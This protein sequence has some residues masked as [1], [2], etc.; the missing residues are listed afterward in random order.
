MAKASTAAAQ[1]FPT[2]VAT[3]QAAPPLTVVDD[4][5]D[6]FIGDSGQGREKVGVKDMA[7]PFWVI[8][9]KTSPEVDKA[10]G[11]YVPG[12]EQGMIFNTVTKECLSGDDGIEVLPCFY[13]KIVIEWTPRESGG[14]LVAVHASDTPLLATAGRNEKNQFVKAG[15]QNLLVETAQHYVVL[16]RPDGTTESGLVA[17]ASTQ[18]KASRQWN[19][20]MAAVQLVGRN[21][22]PFNPPT[23]S[24][25]YRLTTAA[26]S[27]N[28]GSWFGWKVEALDFVKS[29]TMYETAKALYE[30]VKLGTVVARPTRQE[31]GDGPEAAGKSGPSPY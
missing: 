5:T 17:M 18:L 31:D 9:Q 7:I 13:E 21:G 19:S 28:H 6:Q 24:K 3:T 23:F 8:L 10:T 2:E 14:G 22:Q 26:Q 11:S 27:N 25:F 30:A 16:K 12:A 1:K 29:K 20:L 4:L 15:S